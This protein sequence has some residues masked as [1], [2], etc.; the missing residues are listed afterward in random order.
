MFPETT[1]DQ[2]E[3]FLREALMPAL[4]GID[5]ATPP[6]FGK[7]RFP[8]MVEHMT[9]FVRIANGRTPPTATHPSPTW[10]SSTPS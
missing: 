5:P 6:L 3:A 9:D 10:T 2:K 7:M 1:P 8:Q 4:R